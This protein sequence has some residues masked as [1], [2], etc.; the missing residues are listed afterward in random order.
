MSADRPDLGGETTGHRAGRGLLD[1]RPVPGLVDLALGLLLRHPAL[2]GGLALR[3]ALPA[4]AAVLAG[5]GLIHAR[6]QWAGSGILPIL[7][8]LAAWFLLCRGVTAGA[9]ALAVQDLAEGHPPEPG[10]VYLSRARTI[11]HALVP[12]AAA[13]ALLL[14][15][16]PLFLGL[17]PLIAPTWLVASAPLAATGQGSGA[18]ARWTQG[19]RAIHLLLLLGLGWLWMILNLA[20]GPTVAVYLAERLLDVD[21]TWWGRLVRPTHALWLELSIVGGWVLIEPLAQVAAACFVLDLRVR[22]E[23]LDL[24]RLIAAAATAAAL[25]VTVAPLTAQGQGAP[26]SEPDQVTV[27][28]AMERVYARP[29]FAEAAP[30]P[31]SESLTELLERFW[32]WLKGVLEPDPGEEPTSGC[33]GD[34]TGANG[35][36]AGWG[37]VLALLVVLLAL[38]G[39]GMART[40]LMKGRRPPS[41]EAQPGA[42]APAP[43]S[44]SPQ[45]WLEEADRLAAQGLLAEALRHALLALLGALHRARAIDY[46][47]ARTNGDYLND[48]RVRRPAAIEPYGELVRLFERAWYGAKGVGPQEWT[49]GRAAACRASDGGALEA[50]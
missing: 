10:S 38:V 23:G 2:L 11:S 1:A 50:E 13:G 6:P 47:E 21:L 5:L 3:S 4:G 12:S 18:A 7:A 8:G 36:S 27:A 48:L 17:T 26:P 43:L 15:A 41:P 39:L 32:R 19:G 35:A 34:S 22:R 44:R 31:A 37:S 45:A 28:E 49:A 33:A 29:E 20:I 9:V 14:L 25:L 40:R 16:S 46:D 30:G 42:Q 24:K